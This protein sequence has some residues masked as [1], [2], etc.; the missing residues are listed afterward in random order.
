MLENLEMSRDSQSSINYQVL[1]YSK[2]LLGDC[3]GSWIIRWYLCHLEGG[4]DRE[5]V[6]I[7]AYQMGFLG[8]DHLPPFY[9]VFREQ[10]CEIILVR[11]RCCCRAESHH[12]SD[13]DW[14]QLFIAVKETQQGLR[15]VTLPIRFSP[16]AL[17]IG[18]WVISSPQTEN[19]CIMMFSQDV[20]QKSR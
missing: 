3:S 16:G 8:S 1:S 10:C 15:H 6:G 4:G 14:F 9:H 13:S 12:A 5:A 20:S 19:R 17:N 7:L 18:P 11:I 2:P